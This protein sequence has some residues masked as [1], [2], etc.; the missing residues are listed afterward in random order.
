MAPQR[1]VLECALLTVEISAR[2]VLGVVA[3]IIITAALTGLFWFM[4]VAF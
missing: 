1:T 2:V 4:G 3:I